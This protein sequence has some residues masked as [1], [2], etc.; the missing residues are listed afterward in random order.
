MLKYPS[1][2]TVAGGI[3]SMRTNHNYV[4]ILSKVSKTMPKNALMEVVVPN[5][6]PPNS[7]IHV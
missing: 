6:D 1:G 5:E 3:L 7:H 2:G 4:N